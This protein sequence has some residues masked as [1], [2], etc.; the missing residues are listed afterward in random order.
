MKNETEKKL[1]GKRKLF[2]TMLKIGCIGFGGGNALIPVMQQK[3]VEQEKFVSAEDF[4]EDVMVASVTP[5]ALPV[6]IAGGIGSRLYGW[7]GMLLGAIGM[8]F[9]GVLL[10]LV[11]L[12]GMSGMSESVARQIHF[13]T[14]GISAYII[15]LLIDYVVTTLRRASGISEMAQ[16]WLVLSVVFLL[17]CGKTLYRLFGVEGTPMFAI[18]TIHIFVVALFLIFFLHGTRTALKLAVAAILSILYV[19]CVGK[20]SVFPCVVFYVV[21]GCIFALSLYV[22]TKSILRENSC[23]I[24]SLSDTRIELTALFCSV[25]LFAI[26]SINISW[27]A[28]PYIGSGILSSLISFGGGDSYLTV[29][30]GLFVETLLVSEEE[31]YGVIVPLVN[32]LPGSILCKTL[33]GIGYYIGYDATRSLPAA[34]CIAWSGFMASITA[35]CGVFSLVRCLY[36]HFQKLEIF[37]VVRHVIRPIVS[38]ILVTVALA[39]IYQTRNIGIVEGLGW[40]PVCLVLLLTLLNS[41]FYF[42]RGMSNLKIL[43]LSSGLSLLVCNIQ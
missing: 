27:Q 37:H 17:T 2:F 7:Q 9:P 29:A 11:F 43:S 23:R 21:G 1:T 41:W 14:I 40:M 28:L 30:D 18:A 32:L 22:L 33:T 38:G 35:S 6:E 24:L 36:R 42:A 12:A 15:C 10:T 4:E 19:L 39:L 31:F 20:G 8:A 16:I 3:L 25:I 13:L 34:I 5:G 26:P